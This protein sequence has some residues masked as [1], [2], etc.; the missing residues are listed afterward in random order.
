MKIKTKL[1]LGFGVVLVL[2]II[3]GGGGWYGLTALSENINTISRYMDMNNYIADGRNGVGNMEAAS[4]RLII[5]NDKAYYDKATDRYKQ[6]ITG[7][8]NSKK[9]MRNQ[10]NIAEAVEVEKNVT[11]YYKVIDSWWQLEQKCGVLLGQLNEKTENIISILTQLIG[12]GRNNAERMA[13][14][15]SGRIGIER[16]QRNMIYNNA[17]N[18]LFMANHVQKEIELA[19]LGEDI[20]RLGDVW[21]KEVQNSTSLLAQAHDAAS[22]ENKTIIAKAQKELVDYKKIGNEYIQTDVEMAGY[23]GEMRKHREL[24][25]EQVRDIRDSVFE[26]VNNAVDSGVSR[27]GYLSTLIIGI[28]CIAVVLGCFTAV[29]LTRMILK[30]VSA[31]VMGAQK[32][33]AGDLNVQLTE[34]RD[35]MGQMGAGLNSMIGQLQI[36]SEQAAEIADGN[37]DIEVSVASQKDSLGLAFQKMVD[38]L[39]HIIGRVLEATTQVSIAASEVSGA[40]QSLSQ[41][42]T[43][44]AASLEEITASMTEL[45]SRTSTNAE[46]AT[47]ANLLAVAAA[48]AA[49]SGLKK[50]NE[51][52]VAMEGIQA[53]AEQ[54]QRV[55]KAIDDIA[56]QTNLLAL[57]AAVEAARAGVHGKGFAVVAEEVRN[58]AARSAKAAQETA[59][60]IENSNRQINE[61][62]GISRNTAEA[63][64]EIME[65]VK[66]TSDI[67][68]EIA[69]AS[70]EQAQG[71]SQVNVG[72][73]QVDMVTQTNTANAEETAAA[74]EEMA[75]QSEML[76]HQVTKFRLKAVVVDTSKKRVQYKE[77][78]PV[79]GDKEMVEPQKQIVLDDE[80]FGK[81]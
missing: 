19:I 66:K 42:S 62:V 23:Y 78:A 61:G 24:T 40:S 75:S 46:N 64:N 10:Q 54:T 39:N 58:L 71:I 72:L 5:Y 15:N 47:Q 51:L 52:T 13:A 43:E 49:T 32:I 1:F 7:I 74:A 28:M 14:E 36:K 81:F 68:G 31:V 55:I 35:E 9:L 29:L 4:L 44:T 53:N 6:G 20:I 50:M 69:V 73:G 11:G 17:R 22:A 76:K 38:N 27:A 70:N 41:G 25:M 16:F 57:N 30:P 48:D 67:I 79:L 26:R 77:E 3:A 8:I 2:L 12:N 37:L 21:N 60:L 80:E 65:N 18:A 56:F 59:S 45:G 34:G 63:L 33:S